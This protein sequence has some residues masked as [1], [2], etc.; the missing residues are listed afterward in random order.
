M[1][2]L[3]TPLYIGV[4]RDERNS[5]SL[6]NLSTI[7]HVI[8]PEKLP[9]KKVQSFAEKWQN[10]GPKTC[11]PQFFFVSLHHEKYAVESAPTV[12]FII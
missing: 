12:D 8:S 4:S 11:K 3:K 10:N 9:N 2:S 6:P 5:K 7:S 1:K